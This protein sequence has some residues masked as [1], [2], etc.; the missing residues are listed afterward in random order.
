MVI[1]Y[2]SNLGK[3]QGLNV[4]YSVSRYFL[5]LMK[6]NLQIQTFVGTSENAVKSQIFVSMIVYLL[7]ALIHRVYCNGKTAFSIFF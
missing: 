2:N 6:H 7:L 5:K 3:K 4:R 1:N